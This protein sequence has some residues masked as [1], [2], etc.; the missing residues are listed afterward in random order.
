MKKIK[1]K[2]KGIF[3]SGFFVLLPAIITIWILKVII[4]WADDFVLSLLPED[5]QPNVLLGYEIPGL[6]I[7]VTISLIFITGLVTR[8]YVG[9]LLVSLGDKIISK[10]PLGRSIYS[11]IKQFVNTLS[12]GSR[13]N[14]KKVVAV[15]Y[16]RRGSYVIGFLTSEALKEIS[17]SDGIEDS[18]WMNIFIPTTPNPTSGFLIMVPEKDIIALKMSVDDAFKLLI[19]GGFIQS[20]NEEG[21]KEE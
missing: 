1:N 15:E 13:D 20:K 2:L 17:D 9:R 16:P 14:L 8:L 7:V 18:K 5:I 11:A 3:V 10:I 19:S 4:V 21:K 6:G 12:S